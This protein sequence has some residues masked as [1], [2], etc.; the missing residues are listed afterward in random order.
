M[1]GLLS[2][3]NEKKVSNLNLD[4]APMKPQSQNEK[5]WFANLDVHN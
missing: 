4:G 2:Y 3:K 5:K 1:D